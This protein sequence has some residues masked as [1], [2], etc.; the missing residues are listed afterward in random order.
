MFNLASFQQARLARHMA[1]TRVLRWEERGGVY[2]S[3]TSHC[4]FIPLACNGCYSVA[5]LAASAG[6]HV[7][8]LTLSLFALIFTGSLHT[9]VDIGRPARYYSG[10]TDGNSSRWGRCLPLWASPPCLS[11]TCFNITVSPSSARRPRGESSMQHPRL[12]TVDWHPFCSKHY[13]AHLG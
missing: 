11:D 4:L 8:V 2:C 7:G 13:W 6:G 5:S 10:P 3:V 1:E 9:A 12:P